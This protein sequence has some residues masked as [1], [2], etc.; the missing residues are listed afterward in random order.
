MRFTLLAVRVAKVAIT[1]R[2]LG[3]VTCPGSQQFSRLR[4]L[5]AEAS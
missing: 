5:T 2:H 3:T 4:R 1:T